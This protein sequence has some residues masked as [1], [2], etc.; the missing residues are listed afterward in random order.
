MT[1]RRIHSGVNGQQ[2][3]GIKYGASKP[4]NYGRLR[5]EINRTHTV[6]YGSKQY[7]IHAFVS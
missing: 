6:N 1:C 3:D 5:Q 2:I 7:E 4:L